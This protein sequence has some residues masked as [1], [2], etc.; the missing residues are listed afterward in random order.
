MKADDPRIGVFFL[1]LPVM[2][3]LMSSL[4]LWG[5]TSAFGASLSAFVAASDIFNTSIN[6]MVGVYLTSMIPWALM[7]Y[8]RFAG[9]FPY[10]EDWVDAKPEGTDK[11]KAQRI[12]N[13][14]RMFA[15]LALGFITITTIIYQGWQII[16]RKPIDYMLTNVAIMAFGVTLSIAILAKLKVSKTAYE[17]TFLLFFLVTNAACVGASRGQRDRLYRYGGWSEFSI[18]N[19]Y[20]VFRSISEYFVAIDKKNNRVL[21]DKDCKV[22][23]RIPHLDKQKLEKTM[24]AQLQKEPT[25]PTVAK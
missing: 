16:N 11:V 9:P 6:D 22:K 13:K 5:Y 23:F 21:I 3:L 18:C 12:H 2:H 14:A 24:S 25:F 1:A 17:L 19:E 15:V 20:A 8:F 10:V 7:M 4:Y